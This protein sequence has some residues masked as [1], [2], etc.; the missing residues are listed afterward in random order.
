MAYN[1]IYY[2]KQQAKI[3]G[4][5]MP[6]KVELLEKDYSGPSSLVNLRD[7]GW[8]LALGNIDSKQ[9]LTGG[10]QKGTLTT[11]FILPRSELIRIATSDAEQFR[12]R[13][14]INGSIK[15]TGK[16]LTG[17]TILHSAEYPVWGEIKAKDLT[18]NLD[19]IDYPTSSAISN[20]RYIT[21]IA[22]ILSE[23]GF[24]IGIHTYNDWTAN[25]LVTTDD[26][27]NQSYVDEFN[28]Q[29]FSSFEAGSFA[30]ITKME[31]LQ[32]LIPPGMV[33]IQWNNVWNIIDLGHLAES[34]GSPKRWE[35]D[36]SGSKVGSTNS[37]DLS[38]AAGSDLIVN[39]PS[40][41]PWPGIKELKF[42]YAH[43]TLI[44]NLVFD[45]NYVHTAS[46]DRSSGIL[47]VREGSNRVLEIS[48]EVE[49]QT[50]SSPGSF[51]NGDANILIQVGD[52]E[53]ELT[54]G[55]WNST[56]GVTTVQVSGNTNILNGSFSVVAS[57]IPSSIGSDTLTVEMQWASVSGETVQQVTWKKMSARIVYPETVST[58][59]SR[60]FRL[61]QSGDFF[62]RKTLN[63]IE[64]G[65]GPSELQTA[66]SHSALRYFAG[67]GVFQA[68][69]GFKHAG[70]TG[71]DYSHFV[72]EN[73]L[74]LHREN[75]EAAD[76]S[77]LGQFFPIGVLD[78]ESKKWF[79]SG[80]S[81]S[82]KSEGWNIRIVNLNWGTSGTDEFSEFFVVKEGG[83]VASISSSGSSGGSATALADL[84]DVTLSGPSENSILAFTGT[85]WVDRDF[86]STSIISQLQ[87][88]NSVTISNSQWGY[89]G[90][91]DQSLKTTAS[92]TLNQLHLSS[93]GDSIDL[94]VR[95][96]R[97]IGTAG[98][99]SGG[100]DLTSN[101]TIS[102]NYAEPLYSNSA[103]LN[104]RNASVSQ[105]GVVTTGT[106]TLTGVK[107][108]DSNQFY[109]S[110]I[111]TDNYSSQ[112]VGWRMTYTGNL[113]VRS[114]YVDEL[115][116]KAFTADIEQALVA[117]DVLG[118]S[119]AKLASDFVIPLSNGGGTLHV[120]D[121]PGFKGMAVFESGDWVRLQVF[122]RSNGLTIADVWGKVFNYSDN[123]DGTQ[124]WTFNVQDTGGVTGLSVWKGSV[125]RDYG[126]SG[127][128]I[129]ER[130]VLDNAGSPWIRIMTWETDPSVSTNYTI[131]YHAGNLASAP[132]IGGVTPEGWGLVSNNVYLSG[133]IIITGGSGISSLSDAGSLATKNSVSWNNDISNIPG[134]FADT[135]S[136]SGLYASATH[137]GYY[138][139]GVWKAY[140]DN[141]G[142]GQLAGGN[143][144]WTTTAAKIA[145]GNFDGEAIWIGNV[146]KNT[147]GNIYIGSF[148]NSFSVPSNIYVDGIGLTSANDGKRFFISADYN[149]NGSSDFRI[150]AF[151]SKNQNPNYGYLAY[152]NG[153]AWLLQMGDLN[154]FGGP[155][156]QG[157][158][159][160]DN[161]NNEVVLIDNSG[162][163]SIGNL[164]VKN[165]LT[166]QNN[167]QIKAIDTV[168]EGGNEYTRQALLDNGRF[169]FTSTD[170]FAN[171]KRL[172]ISTD[173]SGGIPEVLLNSSTSDLATYMQMGLLKLNDG[174]NEVGMQAFSSNPFI[175]FTSADYEVTT[176]VS[177][178]DTG[179][180][181]RILIGNGTYYIKLWN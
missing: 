74:N 61:K 174:S 118:K 178:L 149:G 18:S 103:E 171:E 181:V 95:A 86:V 4:G 60:N 22:D 10:I 135:P 49:V 83:G 136:G 92:P 111:G 164:T 85:Q 122:D 14:W 53:L 100:G 125:V 36:S 47:D 159:M 21:T 101:R 163:A 152:N 169:L 110:S 176:G 94:A 33:V 26:Y 9:I 64:F 31:A 70:G 16:V 62:P 28:L 37:V 97:V 50:D 46:G 66:L 84:S 138:D 27:F 151:T 107:T 126:Q 65:Q 35:Y 11:R 48:G 170:Q 116:A 2:G 128:G 23:V 117:G 132:N 40:E 139:G 17:E 120:E 96:D 134:R 113:D 38:V 180:Y 124:N 146:T 88:I 145:G 158:R 90:E 160:V 148:N 45:T 19:S 87:N 115:L 157:F 71:L 108:W 80:G 109:K 13:L 121:V 93:E 137:F 99:L 167:G 162:E 114:L 67:G 161:N 56:N 52:Q 25:G 73:I 55:S 102:L 29:D 127:D 133:H 91:L 153:S 173:N 140:I 8:N 5:N 15:W 81:I 166:I 131:H 44:D 58:D 168:L 179:S 123:A 78:W 32:K 112:Q 142:E 43:K 20:K 24:G 175:L 3:H 79:F 144:S 63:D 104:I 1:I 143:L 154:T 106:Q 165:T 130:T 155:S 147:A 119:Q 39:S 30:P 12:L 69:T 75:T 6:V 54:G 57:P 141:N 7:Y 72:M 156:T 150:Q 77:I 172:S 34:N 76:V 59:S 82:G 177:G 105:S 89:L 129:I 51:R 68:L 41:R 98:V 42:T